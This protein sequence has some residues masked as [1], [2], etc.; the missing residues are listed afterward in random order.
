MDY[1]EDILIYL[2]IHNRMYLIEATTNWN[3]CKEGKLGHPLSEAEGSHKG[4]QKI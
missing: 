1:F 4:G 2:I 3:D